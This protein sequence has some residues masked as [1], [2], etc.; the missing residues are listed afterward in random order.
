MYIPSNINIPLLESK[1]EKQ[2][3]FAAS[4]NSFHLTG[5][6]A[7]SKKY[8]VMINGGISYK[9]FSNYYDI[10]TN[11]DKY[12][13]SGGN[14]EVMS[15][16]LA[17]DGEFAHKYGEIGIGRYNILHKKLK[18]EIFGG[19][20]YGIAKDQAEGN[21]IDKLNF[22]A[23]YYLGFIQVNM[24]RT[25]KKLDFGWSVRLATTFR[26]FTYQDDQSGLPQSI[27]LNMFHLEPMAFVRIGGEHLKFVARLGLSRSWLYKP[28]DDLYLE[29]GIY[30]GYVTT[31]GTHISVGI[32]YKF[33]IKDK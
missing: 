1:G 16:D 26:D 3:E 19:I 10:F 28:I 15:I 12:E 8:S 25:L 23:N 6:Y 32:N 21:T 5:N 27:N 11:T 4:T 18:F 30:N 24:G 33:R 29:K 7:F 17:D 22:D 9:N 14:T 2:V 20:G 13:G 31:T